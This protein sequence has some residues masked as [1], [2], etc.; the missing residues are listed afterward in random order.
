RFAVPRDHHEILRGIVQFL[1]PT[2]FR[3]EARL[4]DP[5]VAEITQ[6]NR[7]IGACL[8]ELV[9]TLH[10][11]VP[12]PVVPRDGEHETGFGGTVRKEHEAD[13]RRQEDRHDGHDDGH[14]EKLPHSLPAPPYVL[15]AQ[16]L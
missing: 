2:L 6:G 10:E 13:S 7:E 14:L 1:A 15:L 5:H 8:L 12:G 4:G 16:S 3:Y 11:T 9:E